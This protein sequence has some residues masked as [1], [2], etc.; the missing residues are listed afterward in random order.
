MEKEFLN[1]VV[2]NDCVPDELEVLVAAATVTSGIGTSGE[3]L[4]KQ[5]RLERDTCFLLKDLPKLLHLM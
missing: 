5:I 3:G 4:L 2:P 1:H